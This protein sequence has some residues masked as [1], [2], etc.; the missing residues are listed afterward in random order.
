MG[1]TKDGAEQLENQKLRNRKDYTD[2]S[3]SL[4]TVYKSYNLTYY[5]TSKKNYGH[6]LLEALA[7]E[8]Y[9]LFIDMKLKYVCR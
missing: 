8:S 6:R 9:K 1:L 3:S 2:F 4:K 5:I 7:V